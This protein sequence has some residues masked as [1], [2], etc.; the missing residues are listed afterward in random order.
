MYI[1]KHEY[2]SQSN[3]SNA[4]TL[5]FNVTIAVNRMSLKVSRCGRFLRRPF[6]D[7]PWPE[8]KDESQCCRWAWQEAVCLA[9]FCLEGASDVGGGE[10]WDDP[11]VYVGTAGKG[12]GGGPCYGYSPDFPIARIDIRV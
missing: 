2:K 9:K 5:T 12:T 8:E 1:Y 7:E 11:S 4:V 10:T 3:S 6:G